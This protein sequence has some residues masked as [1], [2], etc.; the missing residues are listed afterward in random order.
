[1]PGSSVYITPQNAFFFE[2]F[3]SILFPMYII[4]YLH[5]SV[6]IIII[7]TLNYCTMKKPINLIVIL[8]F[9]SGL[10]VQAQSPTTV[11]PKNI[12]KSIK[13]VCLLTGQPDKADCLIRILTDL[14]IEAK[15]PPTL[16]LA[17]ITAHMDEVINKDW[18]GSA[19]E[20]RTRF[21]YIFDNNQQVTDQYG[22]TWNGQ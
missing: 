5:L 16:N 22:F 19:W 18:V 7:Y 2:W 10:F 6:F 9:A 3:Y 20:N 12:D 14:S 11:L 17:S 4:F 15:K 21:I 8:L 1:M 13:E